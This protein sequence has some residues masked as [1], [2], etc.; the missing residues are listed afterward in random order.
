MTM[1][2]NTGVRQRLDQARLAPEESSLD[3]TSLDRPSLD[4][5]PVDRA[6][7]DQAPVD[8]ALLDRALL[9]RAPLDRALLDQ[10]PLRR[11]RLADLVRL[12]AATGEWSALVRYTEDERWYH[13]LERGENHEVWL[14]SW[15]P[16]QRTGFHDH[17][18]SSGAFV[19][20]Q[21]ELLERT[22][23]AGRPRPAAAA[24]PAGRA[25]SFG[26]RHVHE[27]VNDSA[28]PAVSIHAYSPPLAGMR[29][30]ELTQSGLVLAAVENAGERW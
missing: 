13:R 11:T 4:Q 8:R 14:L 27:V 16:G 5:S 17:C 9:D 1:L 10:A 24:F 20:V 6:L 12:A 28:A 7:L 22:P 2:A 29:R 18:G 21:G 3:R 30:Y 25:R 26:P 23:A 19:V 15:L